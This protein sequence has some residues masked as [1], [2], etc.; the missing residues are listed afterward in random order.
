MIPRGVISETL[1]RFVEGVQRLRR[2]SS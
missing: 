1:R 2:A